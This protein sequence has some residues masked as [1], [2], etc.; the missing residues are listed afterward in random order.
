MRYNRQEAVEVLLKS[1]QAYYD[2]TRFDEEQTPLAARC[3]F[4]EHS[5]KYVMSRRAQLWEA[6]SEE[7]LYLFEVPHLTLEEYQRCEKL[8]YED[9][10]SRMNIGPGHMY[11]YIT[12][13]F[14]CD[15]WDEDAR[16]A[17]KKSRYYKSFHFA[18]HGWMEYHAAAVCAADG[19][20]VTNRAGHCVV[21]TLKKVLK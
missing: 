8:A 13:I 3:E 19:Q 6:N 1:F 5:E 7:F 21:K 4:F 10:T 20:L 16:R 9:G 15:S 12:A 14:I 11:T 2:I 18:L 17:L